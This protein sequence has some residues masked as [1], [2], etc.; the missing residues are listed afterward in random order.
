MQLNDLAQLTLTSGGTRQALTS[1]TIPAEAVIISAPS[2]NSGVVYLGSANVSSTRY[3]ATIAA[4][5]SFSISVNPSSENDSSNIELSTIYW[6][7]TTGD[8]LNVG[9]LVNR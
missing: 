9:Y 8:K 4:G 5:T 7:G 3:V 1:S 6:D 2:T